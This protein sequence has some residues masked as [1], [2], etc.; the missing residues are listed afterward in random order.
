MNVVVK[1]PSFLH[2]ALLTYIHIDTSDS[3]C[4]RELTE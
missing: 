1:D 4:W 3:F 2:V